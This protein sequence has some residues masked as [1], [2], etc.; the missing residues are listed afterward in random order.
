MTFGLPDSRVSYPERQALCQVSVRHITFS[1]SASF[2]FPLAEDTLAF[3]YRI[4][5]VTA[6]SGLGDVFPA[7]FSILHAQHTQDDRATPLDDIKRIYW[8]QAQNI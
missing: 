8:S 7:P 4:P 3:D 1:S 5:V 6:P 2:R